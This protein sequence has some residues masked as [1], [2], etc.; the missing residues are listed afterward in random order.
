MT[1]FQAPPP[2]TIRRQKDAKGRSF[3]DYKQVEELRRAM[4]QNGKL[5]SRRRLDLS[6]GDQSMV[7]QAIKRARFLALLPFTNAAT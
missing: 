5:L 7:A 3:I 6:A 2:P 4:T 1:Q